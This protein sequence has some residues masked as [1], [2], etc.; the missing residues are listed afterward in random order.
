MV[1]TFLKQPYFA[2]VVILFQLFTFHALNEVM[3]ISDLVY[4]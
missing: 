4:K 3:N 2:H 1:T